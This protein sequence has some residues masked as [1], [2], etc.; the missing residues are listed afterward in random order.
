LS[1]G[2]DDFGWVGDLIE[3]VCE[4]L[5]EL[6]LVTWPL[7]LAVVLLLVYLLHS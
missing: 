5:V 3:G 7:I 4:L 2:D 6:P 1:D